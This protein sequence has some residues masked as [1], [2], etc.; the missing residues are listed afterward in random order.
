MADCCNDKAC[1]IEAL[2]DRQSSI[3]KIV[4]AINAVMF[5][6]ELTAGLLAG[7]VSLIAD[8]LDMLGDA[9]VYGFSIYVVARGARMK[10]KAAFLKG[11]IMAAFGLFV[12][13]QAVFKMVFPQVPVFEAIGAIGLLA[14]A[15][16]SLCLLL[17]WRHR[18][19]DINMSSVWLCS[20]NDIIANVSVL[21]AAVGV[22]LTSSGWPDILVGLALS[23]L[24]LR[25]ALFVLR[26][27]KEELRV[28][29]T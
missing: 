21:C 19:D 28:I 15:A 7:S 23:A 25:S 18:A 17:L 22:W 13:G 20:R 29:Q 24:F 27:A 12:F 11:A 1:E 10:A 5:L 4:L 6:V 14:L 26:G 16:N 3:L 8:S 9:L 2:Q